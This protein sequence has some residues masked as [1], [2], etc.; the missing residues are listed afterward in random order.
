M[1]TGTAELCQSRQVILW[2]TL[3][4]ALWARGADELI[5]RVVIQDGEPMST[6]DILL[7]IEA[8]ISGLQQVKALLTNAGTNR[9]RNPGR[10]VTASLLDS[11][12]KRPGLS[13]D[14]RERIATAQSARWAKSK[15]AARKAARNTA[16]ASSAQKAATDS[17][18][19]KS[20]NKRTM[21]PEARGRMAAGQRARWAK[22]KKAAKKAIRGTAASSAAKKAIQAKAARN[23]FRRRRLLPQ[24]A[25]MHRRLH[26][27]QLP[28]PRQ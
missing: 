26:W 28:Q 6:E 1:V 10:P 8:E 25:L 24:Q 18:S 13:A 2:V 4:F 9:S 5:C 3:R 7:Q 21:S 27:L 17:V 14:A 22:A 19:V 23:L 15:R 12:R 20:T 11:H 16:A